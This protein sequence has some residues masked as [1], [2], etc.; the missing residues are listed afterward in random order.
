MLLVAFNIFIHKVIW[1]II[2][3]DFYYKFRIK[4]KMI[5]RKKESKY[6]FYIAF[7]W[8]LVEAYF[9]QYCK[10]RKSS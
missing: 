7:W 10:N 9:D 5:G 2:R 3:L 8:A 4:S 6:A 1:S